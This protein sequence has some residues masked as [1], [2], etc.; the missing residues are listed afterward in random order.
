MARKE[1]GVP[2]KPNRYTQIIE[3]VFF[4]HYQQGDTDVAFKRSEIIEAAGKLNIIDW[5]C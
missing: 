5:L 3:D 1:I 2:N 4:Q